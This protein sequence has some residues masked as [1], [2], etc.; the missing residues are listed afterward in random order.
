[1]WECRIELPK[2]EVSILGGRGK[3]WEGR[4]GMFKGGS[5]IREGGVDSGSVAHSCEGRGRVDSG[6]VALYKRRVYSGREG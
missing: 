3:L 2:R 1:M 5:I 4:I 6:S